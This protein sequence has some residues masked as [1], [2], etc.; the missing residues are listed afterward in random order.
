[1]GTPPLNCTDGAVQVAA[2][3]APAHANG[4]APLKPGPGINFRLK[5]A[6]CPAVTV[7]EVEP[8]AAGEIAKAGL[9]LAL[10]AMVWGELGASW[11]MVINAVR[12][13]V[14]IEESDI[15]MLQ[16]VPAA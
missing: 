13:P 8:A 6:V 10:S 1:M 11:A 12:V 14:A 2:V 3:G 9:T 4:E 16:E 7:T 5:E 15:P